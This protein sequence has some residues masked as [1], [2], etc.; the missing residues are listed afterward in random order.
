MALP[1]KKVSRSQRNHR[2]AHEKIA[3]PNV[4]KCPRCND[5]A[6]SHRPCPTCGFYKGVQV[7]PAK[8]LA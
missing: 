7:M 3:P 6:M 2:R 1:K 8:E 4:I 5:P